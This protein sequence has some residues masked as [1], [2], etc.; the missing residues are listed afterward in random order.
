MARICTFL[1]LLLGVSY[2]SFLVSV[3]GN[4]DCSAKKLHY[5]FYGNSCPAVESRVRRIVKEAVRKETRM[6]ASLL[7]LHFHDCFVEGCDGSLLLKS[8]PGVLE[9][10]QEAAPNYMS[11]RGYDVVDDIKAVLERECPGIV[12]CADILA[13]AARDSVSLTGGPSYRVL[14]GR[15]DSLSANRTLA[16]HYLPGYDYN[17]S[18]LVASFARV[19]LSPNDMVALSGAHTIGKAGCDT[20]SGRIPPSLDDPAALEVLYAKA[21]SEECAASPNTTLINLDFASPIVFDNSYYR[22]LLK[23]QGVLYSDQVLFST[24]GASRDQTIRYAFDQETF[25]RDFSVAMVNMGNIAPLTGCEG[26]IRRHCGYA[27]PYPS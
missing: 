20:L 21:L 23:N 4:G 25:F 2:S 15:R 22:N 18:Y 3:N 27:N 26:Q 6:A 10:E 7:R 5:N 14:L 17:T 12:S 9:G 11:V 24:P 16:E 1:S 19:G 13:L 8:I